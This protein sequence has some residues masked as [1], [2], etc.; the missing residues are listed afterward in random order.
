[1]HS[2]L[3]SIRY[4]THLGVIWVIS[5]V[6][7]ACVLPPFLVMVF[8]AGGLFSIL[9]LIHIRKDYLGSNS[10]GSAILILLL[11][12]PIGV[13]YGAFHSWMIRQGFGSI[14]RVLVISALSVLSAIVMP[15]AF[16][17]TLLI[18]IAG[19]VSSF[20]SVYGKGLWYCLPWVVIIGVL[21]VL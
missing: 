4:E 21:L 6:L 16:Q 20:L 5:F 9:A 15:I 18:S 8:I 1:M 17:L 12:M 2:Y 11:M 10:L 19:I 3:Q 14:F 7:F 13:L